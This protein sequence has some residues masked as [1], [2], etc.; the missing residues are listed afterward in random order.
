M[1]PILILQLRQIDE[2]ADNEYEAFLHHGHLKKEETHR[3][4]MERES[5]AEVDLQA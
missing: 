1:K 2:V 4:R 3:I 5:I